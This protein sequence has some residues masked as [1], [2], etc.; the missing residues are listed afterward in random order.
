MDNKEDMMYTSFLGRGWG[1]PPAFSV[2]TGGVGM[3]SDEE[4][5]EKSLEILLSTAL[6]ERILRPDYG[7]NLE[8]L[9]F[10]PLSTTLKT[11]VLGLIEQAILNF[12]PS[13]SLDAI[14][15]LPATGGEGRLHIHIDYTVR[16]TNSRYNFVYPFYSE[17]EW[18]M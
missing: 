9:I 12:E 17:G 4:D 16:T 5:I 8:A 10:E 6:G 18:M 14:E 15:I 11:Y 7:C 1:F 3:T 13:I 2:S